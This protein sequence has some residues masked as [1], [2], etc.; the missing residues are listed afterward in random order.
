[1]EQNNAFRFSGLGRIEGVWGVD[2]DFWADPHGRVEMLF[3]RVGHDS[4]VGGS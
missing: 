2:N 1:M 3:N 4:G